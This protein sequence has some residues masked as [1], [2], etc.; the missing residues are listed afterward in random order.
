M[1]GFSQTEPISPRARSPVG[2]R[3]AG[4]HRGS[5]VSLE[6]LEAPSVA[7]PL[8]E[9][10]GTRPLRARGERE[11]EQEKKEQEKARKVRQQ[12]RRFT[13]AVF[14]SLDARREAASSSPASATC[15]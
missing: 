9:T 1:R 2:N 3:A 15:S 7:V 6:F 11:E 13:G 5:R 4:V 14:L 12:S 8:L 10:P